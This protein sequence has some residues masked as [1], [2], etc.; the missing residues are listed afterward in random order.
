MRKSARIALERDDSALSITRGRAPFI[1]RAAVYS[2]IRRHSSHI[3]SY[4]NM[5]SFDIQAET[6]FPSEIRWISLA[7]SRDSSQA[8]ISASAESSD[9]GACAAAFLNNATSTFKNASWKDFMTIMNETLDNNVEDAPCVVQLQSSQKL[10]VTKP[11]HISSTTTGGTNRA[12]LIGIQ[13]GEASSSSS[14]AHSNVERIQQYLV[15][16]ESF[17]PD[18]ITVLLDRPGFAY[19]PS[20]RNILTCFRRLV[21]D[22]RAGD[23]AFLYFVGASVVFLM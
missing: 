7:T 15:E 2:T 18:E 1:T 12:I 20:R 6:T 10:N 19:F 4:T 11:W 13:Y 3:T 17:L 23:S 9:S 16:N 22:S 8:P 14:A 5:P 21:H